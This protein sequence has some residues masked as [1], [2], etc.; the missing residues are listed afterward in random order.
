MSR[1]PVRFKEQL[2]SL[3]GIAFDKDGTLI[4]SYPYWHEL[5]SCQKGIIAE[6][7]GEEVAS[8]WEE[9]VGAKGGVFD[10]QGPFTTAPLIE[11]RTLLAGLL[12]RS[13]KWPWD[14][15]RKKAQCVYEE[16]NLLLAFAKMIKPRPGVLELVYQLKAAGVA[17]GIVTSDSREC[18]RRTLALIG[19]PESSWDFFYT[20]SDGLQP[21]PAPDMVLSACKDIGCFPQEMAVIGDSIMDVKM[22][23]NAGAIAVGVP[24]AVEDIALLR[25][26][27]DFVLSGLYD[28]TLG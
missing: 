12:Y 16:T 6:V 22:A 25:L 20:G 26:T 7:A 17:V 1:I 9:E 10:R 11:E 15:C 24:E 14:I 5:W 23:K 2:V 27:A 8:L 3:R 21:K 18:A 4:E 19:L 28:I 13:K